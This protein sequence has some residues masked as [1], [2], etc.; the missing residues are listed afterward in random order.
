MYDDFNYKICELEKG[1]TVNEIKEKIDGWEEIPGTFSHLGDRG[2]RFS[3]DDWTFPTVY[4]AGDGKTVE[5]VTKDCDM[6]DVDEYLCRLAQR[7]GCKIVTEYLE[8]S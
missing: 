4:F 6:T 3:P 8:Y 5:V 1:M 2:A 7:L